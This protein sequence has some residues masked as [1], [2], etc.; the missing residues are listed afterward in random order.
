VTA[1]S[2]TLFVYGTLTAPERAADVVDEFAYR[3]DAVCEGLGP[4]EGRYPTLAPGERIHGR[5]LAVADLDAVDE[6]EGVD[7]GLYVRV[8]LPR[9]DGDDVWTYVGDPARLG[10]ADAVDWPGD[11]DLAERVRAY[12]RDHDVRVR[13]VE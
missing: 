8:A 2:E 13:T 7:R 6:Y 5:L 9:V 1:R 4:V 11:G 12:V 3:G 10:V